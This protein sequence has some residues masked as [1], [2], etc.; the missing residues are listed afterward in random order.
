MLL[1]LLAAA[2]FFRFYNL[3]YESLWLDEIY[4]MRGSDPNTSLSDVYEYSKHDQPPLFFLCCM[5]G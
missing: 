5:V 4:S 1:V 2:A 3:T